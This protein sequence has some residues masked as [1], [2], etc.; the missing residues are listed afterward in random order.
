MQHIEPEALAVHALGEQLPAAAQAHVA[1]CPVCAA[2]VRS[3]R[4]VADAG[5][6]LDPDEALVAPPPAVWTRI[7]AETGVDPGSMN[8]A[9]VTHGT[10]PAARGNGAGLGRAGGWRGGWVLAASIAGIIVGAG[11][12]AGWQAL[13]PDQAPPAVA[14]AVLDPL[15]DPEVAGTATLVE[16]DGERELVVDVAAPPDVDG[17]L[18]V[19]LLTPDASGLVPL[20]VLTGESVVFVVPADLDLADFPVVD[21]SVEPFD[22][23][24]GHSGDSVVR[25]TLSEPAAGEGGTGA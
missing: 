21:V 11:G 14:T 2:E 22:G 15:A 9:A 7:A 4:R 16:A 20:G 8:V 12:V 17:F 6:S 25:G 24:P 19:W 13:Q 10:T 1:E 5:R 18:Q 23:D 3:L